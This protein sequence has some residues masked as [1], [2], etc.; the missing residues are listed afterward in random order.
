[1]QKRYHANFTSMKNHSFGHQIQIPFLLF[2]FYLLLPNRNPGNDAWAYAAAARWGEELFSPHHLIYNVPGRIWSLLTGGWRVMEFMQALNAFAAFATLWVLAQIFPRD[3]SGLVRMKIAQGL[4][5]TSFV[6]FHYATE[7]EAYMIPIFL[8]MSA[9]WY[10]QKERFMLVAGTLLTFAALFHQQHLLSFAAALVYLAFIAK[11]PVRRIVYF[12]LPMLILLPLAYTGAWYHEPL[13][14]NPFQYFFHDFYKGSATWVAGGKHWI[15]APIN[16]GR[17]FLYLHGDILPILQHSPGQGIIALV[18]VGMFLGGFILW[19]IRAIRDFRSRA[20]QTIV[21]ISE[22]GPNNDLSWKSLYLLGFVAHLL[23]ALWFG[24]NH[25]FMVPLSFLGAVLL[26]SWTQNNQLT[27][28][29]WV[30][31]GMFFWNM[32]LAGFSQRFL[33]LDPSQHLAQLVQQYPKVIWILYDESRVRHVLNYFEGKQAVNLLHGPEWYSETGR[34]T[35]ELVEIIREAQNLGYS[36]YSDCPDRPRR[37][38]RERFTR[39]E[40]P[41]FWTAFEIQ[42]FLTL[43]TVGC[44]YP[45]S[46]ILPPRAHR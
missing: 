3:K 31:A 18:G 10:I 16:L 4:S 21:P 15:L 33:V 35:E 37:W 2:F 26:L 17:I 40:D 13:L 12:S 27:C 34:N 45:I 6:V 9:F 8:M 25:E 46:Q 1:M 19:S 28:W 22:R 42:H 44:A 11:N 38:N 20:S 39:V 7:N 29:I 14:D 30:V 5:G 32:S 23:F 24:A 43:E 36:V 41:K